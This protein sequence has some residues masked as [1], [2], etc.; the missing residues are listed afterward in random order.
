MYDIYSQE[1]EGVIL[2]TY[3]NIFYTQSNLRFKT[4]KMTHAKY[5]IRTRLQLTVHLSMISG[6]K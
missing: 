3:E 2:S 1:Y 5:A 6:S 4:Q